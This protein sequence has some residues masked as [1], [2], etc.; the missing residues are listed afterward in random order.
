MRQL[1]HIICDEFRYIFCD[2]GVLLILVFAPLIYA[3]IYS[4]TYGSQVLR[5]I[6]IGVI[7]N[8]RTPT[9]RK[10][11]NIIGMGANAY[12]AYEPTDMQEAEELF[13]DRKIYGIAYI[14]KG[15]ERDLIGGNQADVAIY[16][17]ASYMLMYRQVFQEMVAGITTTG[18]MVEFQRMIAK[19][20]QTPQAEAIVQPVKQ[21]SRTLFNPYLGYGTFVMPPV[22][23]LILQQ[24]LLI[25]IGM[26]GGTLRERGLHPTLKSPQQLLRTICGKTFTYFII[27]AVLSFYL[28]NIHYRL[29][30]YPMNG[31][32]TDIAIFMAL[33]LLSTI[34][35]A[36]AVSTLFRRRET[37][38]MLLLWTSIPLLML[39]GVSFPL[40]AIPEWLRWVA[41]I[42]PSSYGTL[43]FIKLQTMGAS[44]ADIVTEIKALGIMTI[45]YF[46]FAYI[47]LSSATNDKKSQHRT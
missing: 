35:M 27:Y 12:V 43:G 31:N 45:I 26:I 42:F 28:L 47:G 3:T 41:K 14:P 46:M 33:Y 7:D 4:L 8:D 6:P 18:A 9:S 24:T 32:S 30:H 22:I 44:L 34:F 19:G 15:Y 1:L 39:S 11:I 23:I 16:L 10:L 25:G 38:L 20:V 40:S 29:F 21:V 13:F 5:N 37:P 2:A 36:I 17:D